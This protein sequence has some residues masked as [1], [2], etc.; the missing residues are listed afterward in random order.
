MG[1]SRRAARADPRAPR[2]RVRVGEDDLVLV[3]VL[4]NYLA[5]VALRA[6]HDV[7]CWIDDCTRRIG[8]STCP[9]VGPPLK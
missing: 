7:R 3:L 2:R 5:R 6:S 4:G 8:C 1:Q 9:L